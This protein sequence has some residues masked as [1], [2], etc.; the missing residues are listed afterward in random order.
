MNIF[1]EALEKSSG[2]VKLQPTVSANGKNVLGT[3][4]KFVKF[5]VDTKNSNT[6]PNLKLSFKGTLENNS[7]SLNDMVFGNVFDTEHE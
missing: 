7:G 6:Y 4:I 2:F 5:E 3:P 1:E